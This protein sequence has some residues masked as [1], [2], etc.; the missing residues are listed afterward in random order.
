MKDSILKKK[1]KAEER[2]CKIVTEKV[3]PLQEEI[4]MYDDMI[5]AIDKRGIPKVDSLKSE[6]ISPPIKPTPGEG[7]TLSDTK[8]PRFLESEIAANNVD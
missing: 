5:L 4:A 7:G 1:A 2:L 6:R 8:L 3:K